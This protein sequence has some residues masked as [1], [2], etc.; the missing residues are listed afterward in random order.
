MSWGGAGGSGSGTRR[1]NIAWT[2]DGRTPCEE[3]R[4]KILGRGTSEWVVWRCGQKRRW[5]DEVKA[6]ADMETWKSG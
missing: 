2:E 3:T 1:A 6:K 4:K 5:T